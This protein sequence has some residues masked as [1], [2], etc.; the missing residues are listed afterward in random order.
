MGYGS[1][2]EGFFIW[3]LWFTAEG[4]E[5]SP[6]TDPGCGLW[7][8]WFCKTKIYGLS[9]WWKSWVTSWRLQKKTHTPWKMNSWH[10]KITW[11][12][13]EK[14]S[15]KPPFLGFHVN[16]PGRNMELANCHDILLYLCCQIADHTSGLKTATKN[17]GLLG[18]VSNFG[19]KMSGKSNSELK[20]QQ[21]LEWIV[22]H[23]QIILERRIFTKSLP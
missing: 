15:S 6:P 18:K 23:W 4:S 19:G 7:I 13:K 9:K 17:C 3:S 22:H 16:L 5:I 14:S 8:L 10:L 21:T 12:E 11:F 20:V 1:F 2:R